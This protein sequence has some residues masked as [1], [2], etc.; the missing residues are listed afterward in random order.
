MAVGGVGLNV[1]VGDHAMHYQ[2]VIAAIVV[3]VINQHPPREE[4]ES[5][6]AFQCKVEAGSN[7]YPTG[8]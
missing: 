6:Q 7:V 2:D 5:V 8:R 3:E 4:L 1:R